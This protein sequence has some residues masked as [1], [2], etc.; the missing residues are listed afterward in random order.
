[1]AELWSL[2]E[3][4]TTGAV[5][6]H[7]SQGELVTRSRAVVLALSLVVLAA[8]TMLVVATVASRSEGPRSTRAVMVVVT[9][10]LPLRVC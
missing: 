8:L 9:K 4:P 7:S 1:L 5:E 6:R 2:E 10:A 3:G